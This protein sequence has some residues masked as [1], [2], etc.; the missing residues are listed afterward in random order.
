MCTGTLVR[1]DQT[2][3]VGARVPRQVLRRPWGK[4][5][6]SPH[7][8]V[9]QSA[10]IWLGGRSGGLFGCAAQLYYSAPLSSRTEINAH[11]LAPRADGLRRARGPS[12]RRPRVAP[13]ARAAPAAAV[14]VASCREGSPSARGAARGVRRSGR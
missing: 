9:V 8:L 3:R 12:P 4:S 14:P 11:S 6:P 2:Q 13:H 10:Q 1:Y 5:P 7:I